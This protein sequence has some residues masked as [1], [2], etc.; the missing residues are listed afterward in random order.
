MWDWIIH[1]KMLACLWV[2]FWLLKQNGLHLANHRE[3]NLIELPCKSNQLY[4]HWI[5]SRSTNSLKQIY[6]YLCDKVFRSHWFD[7][8]LFE[9]NTLMVQRFEMVLFA[10]L[11]PYLAEL[12]S[13]FTPLLVFALQP[14]SLVT[15]KS[16]I[17]YELTR[18]T[19]NFNLVW[20]YNLYDVYFS[21][22]SRGLFMDNNKNQWNLNTKIKRS[23]YSV[24]W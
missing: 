6:I 23:L 5:L 21:R 17:S 24:V 8:S 2:N 4:K 18:K 3:A 19:E 7:I 10:L 22:I 1:S 15:L 12:S 13:C 11:V 9:G 16:V 14:D 20:F